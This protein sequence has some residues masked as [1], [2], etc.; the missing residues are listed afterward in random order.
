MTII[1]ALHGPQAARRRRRQRRGATLVEAALVLP[2]LL[3]FFI[4]VTEYGRY[5]MT[6]DIFNIAA[7]E[8]AAYAAKHTDPIVLGGTTY[9]NGTS[10][11]TNVVNSFLGGLTLSGQSTQVYM[12]DSLGNNLGTWT[13]ATAGQYVCVK[14]TGTYTFAANALLFLPSSVPLTFQSVV[15]CEGN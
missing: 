14:I 7:K 11:V 8:G 9:G 4:G 6:N 10:D 12:S 5:L 2:M 1:A 13:S 3:L 15:L